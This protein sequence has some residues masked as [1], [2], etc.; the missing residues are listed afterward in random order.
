MLGEV[1]E[2]GVSAEF[3]AFAAP[4]AEADAVVFVVGALSALGE[5]LCPGCLEDLGLALSAHAVP[6][7][8]AAAPAEADSLALALA[9]PLAEAE[10]EAATDC[11]AAMLGLTGG[12][13]AGLDDETGE[14]VLAG[15]DVTT[16]PLVRGA[17]VAN[18]DAA[19]DPV[20]HGAPAEGCW[21]G[22]AEAPPLP[23]APPAAACPAEP[24]P[25][26][27]PALVLELCP[28]STD[29][30]SWTMACRNGGTAMATTTANT[31][32]APASAGLSMSSRTSQLP[33]HPARRRDPFDRARACRDGGC[34]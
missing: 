13:V 31:A 33:H 34:G 15:V 25:E 17:V 26:V 2:P 8:D 20:A 7:D 27:V 23:L 12:L 19:A 16:A 32:Q 24:C 4:L 28:V 22:A 9:P 30:P 29:E 18:A 6:L 21:L 5:A 14:D 3:A 11:E 1:L 10:A